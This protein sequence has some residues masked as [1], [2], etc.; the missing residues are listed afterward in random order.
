MASGD[1]FD[2]TTEQPV[3]RTT[4]TKR[5]YCVVAA[6]VIAAIAIFFIGFIIGYFAMKAGSSKT[7]SNDSGGKKHGHKEP[8]TD[9]KRYHEQAVNALNT[10]SVEKFSR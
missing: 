5:F 8:K 4:R 10:E 9:Y 1:T 6:A 7:S 3:K 2:L